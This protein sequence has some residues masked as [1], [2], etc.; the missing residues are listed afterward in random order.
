MEI[1]DWAAPIVPVVKP[2]GSIRICGDYRVTV[3][4]VAKVDAHPIPRAEDLFASLSGGKSF[5][6]LD[7]AHAYLQLPLDEESQKMV[8]I[9]THKGLF[10][11][12]RLPFGISSAPAIFQRKMESILE[13]IPHVCVYIDDILITGP[14]SDEHLASL[15]LVLS[16]LEE[17]GMRLKREKCS[18]LMPSVEYLVHKISAEG[19][20]P[21]DD[22]VEAIKKAPIPQN[23]AELRCFLGMISYYT[24]FLKNLST[25]VAPLNA[26]LK[27][28][29]PWMWGKQQ[30]EAFKQAKLSLMST[31]V[32]THFDPDKK[33]ILECDAS[34]VGV[35]AV[36]SHQL[37][38]G[39]CKP[40]A[41]ASRSLSHAEKNYSQLDREGL[42]IVFGVK[43]FHQ[44][45]YGRKFTIYSDHKP[46]EAI[47]SC[48]K[49]ISTMASARVKRWALTL[50]CYDYTLHY[51]RG[52][53]VP[54]ADSLSR[55]PLPDVPK[56]ETPMPGELVLLLEVLE[57]SP[58]T[59]LMIK[60]WTNQD[61]LLSRIVDMV[62]HGWCNTEEETMKPYQRRREE[63]SVEDGC[64]LWGNR[65][66]VPE[67]GRAQIL[68]LLHEGHPGILRMK[69][70]ARSVA[71]WPGMDEAIEST[72][73]KCQLCQENQK[74]PNPVM[75]HP[76]EWP[77]SPWTRVHADY[78]GPLEG[79]MF[80]I[81]V[82]AYSKWLEVDIVPSA[83]TQNTIPKLRS[84]FATHG[85][86]EVLVTDN[87]TAFTSREF[88][89]FTKR[90]GIQHLTTAPYHPSS[91]GLA[92]RAVQTFK[93]AIEKSSSQ[94]DIQTRVSRF[95]FHYR[96]TPH[97]VTGTPPAELLMKRRPR[98][99][100]DCMKPS[101]NKAMREKQFKQ[102]M[103]TFQRASYRMP[104]WELGDKVYVRNFSA[105]KPKWLPGAIEV[106]HGES[107]AKVKLSDGR[108]VN[109]H[110]D[111]IRTR[112]AP[113]ED[114]TQSQNLDIPI[115]Q[116]AQKLHSPLP[117]RSMRIRQPPD[118][119]QA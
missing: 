46:L 68:S 41:F 23:V 71:W 91:N 24:K 80:L 3:N 40:I 31:D 85:L 67:K 17:A 115:S 89:E 117:R 50:S 63:L 47:F 112:L 12:Q 18:F 106:M 14:S 97:T 37:E 77:N 75:V 100:L 7:V 62:V 66:V 101:F 86:P 116:P 33:L 54:H 27:K 56:Q 70:L 19:I 113:D 15:K 90:N 53:E 103:K 5:S 16:K 88:K 114:E 108:M 44:Y 51:K 98:T 83:T 55:L 118:R 6:K 48:S 79:K 119:F 1:S 52:N 8:T 4:K 107:Q 72:V 92:E 11:Y 99:H 59:S 110:F 32:L 35:G 60:N 64:L 87:R 78:A 102:S 34:P 43:R 26:L 13:G 38:N 30:A 22:K 10:Q 36:L 76:W 61:P 21:M 57:N 58:V 28:G 95:L 93:R 82:D 25:T 69:R 84:I 105:S 111:H 20:L 49:Q 42:A 2:D 109:R 29:E 65:V 94:A 104:Q 39:L 45:L 96:T 81:L 73:N 74:S 9:N